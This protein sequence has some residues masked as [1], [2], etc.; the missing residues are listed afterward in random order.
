MEATSGEPACVW[1]VHLLCMTCVSYAYNACMLLWLACCMSPTTSA[2]P[3]VTRGRQQACQ[4]QLC[5]VAHAKADLPVSCPDTHTG[6][7]PPL[8]PPYAGMRTLSAAR[9]LLN[10]RGCATWAWACLGERRAHAGVSGS[11]GGGA[12]VCVSAGG[13]RWEGGEGGQRG[14]GSMSRGPV[15]QQSWCAAVCALC[16]QSFVSMMM[17]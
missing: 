13:W 4:M 2:L 1:D 7:L 10:P 6:L 16:E 9:P 5:S 3:W 8:F 15:Q 11:V 14:R 17:F 12:I